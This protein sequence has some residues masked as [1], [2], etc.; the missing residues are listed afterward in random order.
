MSNICFASTREGE[1]IKTH[2]ELKLEGNGEQLIVWPDIVCHVIDETSPLFAFNNAKQFN[3]GQFE[4]YVTIVGTSPTT[5]QMTEAKTSYVPREIYWGQRFANIIHYD[6]SH[7]R[8]IVDYENFNSTISVGVAV[9]EN[10]I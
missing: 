5:A 1:V 2:T 4:L 3:A 9:A 6:A 8:Y 7:E 10:P